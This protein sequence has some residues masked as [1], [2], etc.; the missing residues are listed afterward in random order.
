MS[1]GRHPLVR[2]LVFLLRLLQL[3]LI[4]LDPELRVR[5]ARIERE[6]IRRVDVSSLGLLGEDPIL[7]ACKRLEGAL[8]LLVGC[9]K[10]NQYGYQ[11]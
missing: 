7:G 9:V 4:D 11:G 3:N 10:S 6:F 1:V 8:E 5:K 2:L